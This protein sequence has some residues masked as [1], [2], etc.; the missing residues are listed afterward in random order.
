MC[1][2]LHTFVWATRQVGSLGKSHFIRPGVAPMYILKRAISTKFRERYSDQ[3]DGRL[4]WDVLDGGSSH[5]ISYAATPNEF[6][7]IVFYISKWE[8]FHMKQRTRYGVDFVNLRI[9][10]EDRDTVTQWSVDHETELS[11]MVE[12]LVAKQ[13]RPG[14]EAHLP[15]TIQANQRRVEVALMVRD[16]QH[17][18]LGRN[19]VLPGDAHPIAEHAHKL[20]QASRRLVEEPGEKGSFGHEPSRTLRWSRVCGKN[21]TYC[22]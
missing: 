10:R 6:T 3:L 11:E 16:H 5:C 12:G 4:N 7:E 19:V 14:D 13:R 15:W 17:A 20:Q 2:T 21:A 8:W 22:G 1:A 9:P 18:P